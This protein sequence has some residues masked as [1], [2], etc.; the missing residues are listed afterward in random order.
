M[1][2]TR[3]RELRAE[4]GLTV[5]ELTRRGVPMRN[6]FRIENDPDHDPRLSTLVTIAKA[7]DCTLDDLISH[8]PELPTCST[9]DGTNQPPPTLPGVGRRGPSHGE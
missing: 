6:V 7:L 8:D 5:A 1:A 9:G 3:L 4:R 2:V